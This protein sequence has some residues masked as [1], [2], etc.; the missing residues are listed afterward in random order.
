[1]NKQIGRSSNSML[2]FNST[3]NK[4][5]SSLDRLG[6]KSSVLDNLYQKFQKLKSNGGLQMGSFSGNIPGLSSLSN[7]S[8]LLGLAGI[9]GPAAMGIGI[10]TAGITGLISSVFSL[11]KALGPTIAK[12]ETY[13]AVLSNTLG[14]QKQ[15]KYIMSDIV[16]LAKETPE[17]VNSL[18][19][20]W[21]RLAN[22]GFRPT[23]KQM[24]SLVDLTKSTSATRNIVDMSEAIIDAQTGEFE[25]LKEF[26]IKA[27]KSGDKVTFTFKEQKKTVDFTN[28][29]IQDYML[30]LGEM[31]GVTGASDKI[32]KTHA[33]T[34]S[35]YEDQVD[36]LKK[37][38]GYGL[39]PVLTEVI[40]LKS[41][42]VSKLLSTGMKLLENKKIVNSLKNSLV[43]LGDVGS[44]AIDKLGSALENLGPAFEKVFKYLEKTG[45]KINSAL[46][47]VFEFYKWQGK[48]LGDAKSLIFG[49]SKEDQL[50]D[51][52]NKKQE[53]EY[54]I[55]L[56][57]SAPDSQYG[58][59]YLKNRQIGFDN[60][61]LQDINKK[62]KSLEG[63]KIPTGGN[64]ASGW[65]ELAKRR[66][67]GFLND[68]IF[69]GK[70]TTQENNSN[71]PIGSK[72][73][74]LVTGSRDTKNFYVSIDSLIKT[75]NNY[76]QKLEES[77]SKIKTIIEELLMS[78]IRDV[79]V[80]EGSR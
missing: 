3:Q 71:D 14:S 21:V 13:E 22:Q 45:P 28:K 19:D 5:A 39:K 79:Q 29:A 59:K 1:M 12:Y 51:L 78:A 11:E 66:D 8:G 74:G 62:I 23:M 30:S 80:L 25:R 2:S 34:L 57:K 6:K 47:P 49:K 17:T 27:S 56:Y 37:Q 46:G 52:K 76:M 16:K 75:Q 35:N 69:G 77:P 9:G 53:L 41:R 15:A 18:T 7:N 58:G 63:S 54:K 42:L 32:M 38:F 24:K 61:E 50:A 65:N 73:N 70:K 67:E 44:N 55:N 64:R 10:A 31:N 26:G 40:N 20:S 48:L 68:A 60:S 36:D 43:F 4:G 33:G 72:L